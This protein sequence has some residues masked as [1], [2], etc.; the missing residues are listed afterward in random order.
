MALA[1]T[2]SRNR[3][4]SYFQELLQEM[5]ECEELDLSDALRLGEKKVRVPPP[6][7]PLQLLL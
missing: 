5:E 2:E 7:L 3:F 4:L 1:S 6:S